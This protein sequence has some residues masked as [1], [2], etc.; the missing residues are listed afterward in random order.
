MKIEGPLYQ[1][2]DKV[3]DHY[4]ATGRVV[5]TRMI[6]PETIKDY[7]LDFAYQRI[8]VEYHPAAEVQEPHGVF[9]QTYSEG[10]S[11]L[12]ESEIDDD[13]SSE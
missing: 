11:H 8:S 4:G 13:I 12:Y 2:G 3:I 7:A 10:S 6:S 9:Y 5:A 1:V